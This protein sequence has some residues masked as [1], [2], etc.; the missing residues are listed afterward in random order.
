[1]DASR[2][3]GVVEDIDAEISVV[4]PL[5]T[6]LI[7]AYT[8]ARDTPAQDLSV[9]ILQAREDLRTVWATPHSARL[10]PTARTGDLGGR[11]YWSL[12]AETAR[13][14]FLA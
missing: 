1:M 13:L 10:P 7:Q 12:P 8:T 2:L 9:A 14:C 11:L 6:A 5:L 4:L 3:L